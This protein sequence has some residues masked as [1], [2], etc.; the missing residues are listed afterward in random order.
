VVEKQ[1]AMVKSRLDPVA[2]QLELIASLRP[3]AGSTSI[4]RSPC[5]RRWR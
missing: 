2:V 5:A 4:R 3:R 1:V